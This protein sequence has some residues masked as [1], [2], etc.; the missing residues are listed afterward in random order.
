M[1]DISDTVNPLP[2]TGSYLIDSMLLA[3]GA[4]LFTLAVGVV[5]L[6]GALLIRATLL[7]TRPVTGSQGVSSLVALL[8]FSV[9]ISVPAYLLA[10]RAEDLLEDDDRDGEKL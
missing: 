4:I 8:V 6:G 1:R 10:T 9:Y 3:L 5:V 7:V 2:R